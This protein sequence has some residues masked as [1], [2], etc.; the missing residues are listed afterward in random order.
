MDDVRDYW[1]SFYAG[2]SSAAVPEEPSTFA[3]WVAG[4]IA[5]EQPIIEFGFGNG[6]DSFWLARQGWLVRGFEFA[7]S[8]VENAIKRAAHES[9]PTYFDEHDLT[10]AAQT[11]LLADRLAQE[12][13]APVIFGRFLLHSLVDD[14]R[15]NLFDLAST[16]LSG[17]G[18]LYLEFRTGQDK[19]QPHEF[20]DGH[21]RQYL[22]PAAVESELKSRGANIT[23]SVAGKG[24]SVYKSEDPHVAR[25]VA[26]WQ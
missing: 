25:I 7:S 4:R 24:Y 22:D 14:A 5:V 19:G 10:D 20:G 11:D 12:Y 16:V 23:Y 3:R 1:D 9:T 2:K 6:R 26:A 21:Y 8:A 17:S 13:K 18:E 15:W